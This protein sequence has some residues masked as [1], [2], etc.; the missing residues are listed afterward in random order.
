MCQD[1]ERSSGVGDDVGGAADDDDDGGGAD[2]DV[3]G[4]DDDDVSGAADDDVG[5]AADDDD[6]V[7]GAD[8]DDGGA[9][10]DGAGDDD[11][12]DWIF[13]VNKWQSICCSFF[14][15]GFKINFQFIPLDW[16]FQIYLAQKIRIFPV[17]PVPFETPVARDHR[18]HS[19]NHFPGMYG[20]YLSISG[21]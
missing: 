15:C 18:R 16:I 14:A 13:F 17:F 20:M 5:G 3:G 4:A 2:D 8:D 7:G 11:L 12:D 9:D 21:H 6:D 19:I 10:D 1:R